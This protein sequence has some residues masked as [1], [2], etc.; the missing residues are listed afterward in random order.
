MLFSFMT[1]FGCLALPYFAETLGRRKT[2]GLYFLGIDGSWSTNSRV[3]AKKP[4]AWRLATLRAASH[5]DS[6]P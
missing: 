5:L 3:Y 1:I 6:T 4:G 2:T